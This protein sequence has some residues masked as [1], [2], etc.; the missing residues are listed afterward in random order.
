MAE[1]NLRT[2]VLASVETA[3]HALTDS[4][5]NGMDVVR[6]EA[7]HLKAKASQGADDATAAVTKGIKNAGEEADI[8]LEAAKQQA[9]ALQKL[10]AEEL[11]THPLRALGIAAAIGL[12][13]GYVTSR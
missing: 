10:M 1:Q 6:T 12:V 11:R 9:A 3:K 4:L 7:D 2:D 5:A 13:A 8:I